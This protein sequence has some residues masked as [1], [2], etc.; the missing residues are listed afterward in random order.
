MRIRVL[1]GERGG[2]RLRASLAAL[3]CIAGTAIYFVVV[4]RHYPVGG[5]LAW[6]VGVIWA[7]LLLFCA[8]CVG[9]GSMIVERL[10]GTRRLT[11]EEVTLLSM[12]VGVVLLTLGMY[13]GGALAWYGPLFAVLLPTVLAAA[14][15]RPLSRLLRAAR[16]RHPQA[17]PPSWAG[18][19][20]VSAGVLGAVVVYLGVFTP[21]AINYDSAWCHMTVAQDYAREGRIVPFPGDY[22]KNVP[23][24]ASIVYAWGFMLPGL[25]DA[26]AR[27]MMALH[28]EFTLF[29]WTLVG[30]SAAVRWLVQ[31]PVRGIWSSFFLFPYIFVYDHSLGGAADHV[32][33]FFALPILLSA[34]HFFTTLGVGP[35]IVLGMLMGGAALTKYQ[36]VYLLVPLVG[37]LVLRLP[38]VLWSDFR[39]SRTVSWRRLQGPLALAGSLTLVA[40]PHFLKNVMFYGNP[41]YP[42]MQQFFSASHPV[43]QN[44][45]LYAENIFQD[46]SWVPKGTF[47]ERVKSTLEV[48]FTFSFVPHYS[49]TKDVPGFG[50]LF[51]LLLP[52]AV[53]VKGPRRVLFAGTLAAAGV[54]MWAWSF[55]V[56]R[57]L[58]IVLPLLVAVTAALIV[59]LWRLG[60]I[61]RIGLVPLVALQL[62]WGGDA[63]FYSNHGRVKDSI[64]I[65]RSGFEGAAKTRFDRYRRPFREVDKALPKGA[66]VLL[67]TSHGNLGI[68]HELVF[69]WSGFQ[70]LIDYA[71]LQSPRD[72]YDYF[73]KLGI[74][75]LLYTPQERAASSRQEEILW[76][77][78]V[79]RHAVA[80][81]RHSGMRLLG[82]P[83]RPPAEEAP[84][85][86]LC[87]GL[88]GYADGLYDI[89]DLS[90]NEYLVPELRSYRS[91]KIPVRNSATALEQ[92]AQADALLVGASTKYQAKLSSQLAPFVL[93]IK[94]S[95][96]F[97]VYLRKR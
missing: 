43:A 61:A 85:R 58:Q 71:K 75:H 45:W 50:S 97:T 31:A 67:H 23:Q 6:R 51:T 39:K 29:A 90:T 32:L 37:L 33:A 59:E 48:F 62:I 84:Y 86:V 56:D 44:G 63:T 68:D 60:P 7:W 70:G 80:V 89:A 34:R 74:T 88:G 26:P 1:L 12:A 20:A 10:L 17:E 4:D 46:R 94:Y 25:E 8:G 9:G 52:C 55:R 79:S 72:V 35:A 81:G 69:D 41:V 11:P 27:W 5:W 65:I 78:F 15:A 77:A 16:A 21:D 30:V 2:R 3:A 95:G 36:A 49:F 13:V 53:L 19:L 96:A 28:L 54:A 91:P 22:T 64:D 82:M 66:K 57:N 47:F 42:L 87:L 83:E 76:Q 93:A 73:R 18:T 14:G 24:L 38:A 40:S 92:L